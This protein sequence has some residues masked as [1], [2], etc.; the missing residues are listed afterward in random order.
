MRKITSTIIFFIFLVSFIFI[1][2][3]FVL[4][5][6]KPNNG[7]LSVTTKGQTAKIF[8]DNKYIGSTP[9]YK[10]NLKVGDHKVE[11]QS[12]RGSGFRWKTN[13]FLNS[14]TLSILDLDL[15]ENQ[16]FSSG[17][18]LYFKQGISNLSLLTHPD[19]ASVKID[20]KAIGK[21]PQI[22]NLSF[23]IHLLLIEK[24]GY[25]SRQ[26]PINIESGYKLSAII[27][28]SA[29]PFK[30]VTKIDNSA[31]ATFFRITNDSIDLSKSYSDWAGG[32]KH[33]QD[34]FSASETRFDILI[35]PNG[36]VY[37]LNPTEWQNKKQVKSPVNIGYLAKNGN[38]KINDSASKEWLKIKFDFN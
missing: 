18:N 11:I 34:N 19:K 25:L 13:T 26:V 16:I 9:F 21:A 24:D 6:L 14:T 28:L 5:G 33:V 12:S 38:D 15:A 27:Y 2:L 30:E 17:E 10:D 29:N 3:E 23:G 32:I 22:L 35:D 36:K 8:L 1:L 31:K 20:G 7:R 37:I 4:P